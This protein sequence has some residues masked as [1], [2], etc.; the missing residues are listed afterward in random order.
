[1][2]LSIEGAWLAHGT[3]RAL[4]VLVAATID[5]TLGEPPARFHPVVGMGRL[6][7]CLGS[8]APWPLLAPRAAFLRGT[9][10]WLLAGAVCTLIAALLARALVATSELSSTHQVFLEGL[11][12]GFALKPLIA[13]RLLRDEVASVERALTASLDAGRAQLR[14][15][16]SRDTASLCETEVRE[17]AL[18]SLAENLNDSWVAPIFW[19]AVA[20]LPG[21]ALYRFANTADAMW[22]YHGPFEWAGKWT[23]RADDALSYVPARITTVLLALV[24]PAAPRGLGREAA[25]TPSPNGGWPMAMLAIALGVRL[26]KP[27]V[28]ILNPTGRTVNPDDHRRAL[29]IAERAV[30]LAVGIAF[31]FLFLAMER[32]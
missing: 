19:F 20:G 12:L 8:Q 17:S 5:R 18:E 28:Y 27:R 25:R 22:G 7:T 4:A 2:S 11:L 32:H 31:L 26:S 14:R 29:R 6:L 24:S 3:V 15:L 21:A 23:A 1:M 13:W 16:V 30:W 9:I 10:V